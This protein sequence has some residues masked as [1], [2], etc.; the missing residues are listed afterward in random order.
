M[1][2]R[3]LQILLILLIV[4]IGWCSYQ[5]LT[6]DSYG[7]SLPKSSDVIIVLG[8]AVWENGP[9]PALQARIRHAEDLYRQEYAKYLI[10]SGG[11]GQF[12]SSEAQV[13]AEILKQHGIDED[14]LILEEKS[15]NTIENIRLS[16]EKMDEYG[17][18]SAILVTDTFHMKRAM[19]IAKDIG[20]D[21]SGSAAKDSV[22][23]QTK[24]LKLYYTLREVL[25][26]TAYH[27]F[28]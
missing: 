19:L 15:T 5:L 20:M 6:I 10:L 3:W 9:S 22:L 21:V 26:I 2:L 27:L 8:A 24:S 12:G 23:N 16:K 14:R 28:H 11:Q 1:K 13:M 18:T 7:K 4:L 17:F 25:A